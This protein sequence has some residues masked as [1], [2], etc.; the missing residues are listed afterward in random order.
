MP[1]L[2][3]YLTIGGVAAVDDVSPHAD[4][5]RPLDQ[6]RRVVAPDERRVH[7]VPTPTLGGVAMFGGFMLAMLVAWRLDEFDDWCSR[8]R[9]NRS[10]SCSAR[11]IIFTVGLIDDLSQG[12]APGQARRHGARRQRACR[13][14]ASRMF[15]FRVPFLG[16]VALTPDLVGRSSPC[17]GSSGMAN[18]INFIDGLDG[19]AA[20]TVAIAAGDVLRVRASASTTRRLARRQ[21]R[22]RRWSR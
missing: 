13:C 9:P 19:L 21:G 22:S 10:A 7:K 20:G 8:R 18:A 3:A 17:C 4:R 15:F 6:V 12:S 2:G 11:S 16:L 5:A 1:G 14:S